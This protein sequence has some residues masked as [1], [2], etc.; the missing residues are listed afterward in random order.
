M[1]DAEDDPDRLYYARGL[2]RLDIDEDSGDEDSDALADGD[3]GWGFDEVR[4]RVR[5]S[6]GGV[7]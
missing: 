2:G 4:Y 6:L 5:S 7:N 1:Y 3:F